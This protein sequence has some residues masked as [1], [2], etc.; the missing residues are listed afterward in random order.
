M[1]QSSSDQRKI[2]HTQLSLI[3]SVQILSLQYVRCDVGKRV[4]ECSHV[5]VDAE[6]LCVDGGM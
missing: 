2:N 6:L 3:P 4:S 5:G 1:D